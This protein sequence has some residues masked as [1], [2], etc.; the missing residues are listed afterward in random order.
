MDRLPSE[1]LQIIFEYSSDEDLINLPYSISCKGLTK[2]ELI[3]RFAIYRGVWIE[4]QSLKLLIRASNHPLIGHTIQ[5]LQFDLDRIPYICRCEFRD[6]HWSNCPGRSCQ[7]PARRGHQL[8]WHTAKDRRALCSPEAAYT[9]LGPPSHRRDERCTECVLLDRKWA[10]YRRDQRCTECVLLGRKWARYRSLY[11]SQCRLAEKEGDIDI[12]TLAFKVLAS[13]KAITIANE[14]KARKLL[15]DT[16]CEELDHNRTKDSGAHLMKVILKALARSGLKLQ[17]FRQ[18]VSTGPDGVELTDVSQ[19]LSRTVCQDIFCHL[20]VLKLR[21]IHYSAEE[22]SKYRQWR[23]LDEDVFGFY[24]RNYEHC[25]VGNLSLEPQNEE[26]NA[27]SESGC[28][29]LTLTRHGTTRALAV[30]LASCPSIEDLQLGIAGAWSD[31]APHIPLL[32][33]LGQNNQLASLRRLDLACCRMEEDQLSGALLRC[34][35]TLEMLSLYGIV[36]DSGTWTSLFE[37]LRGRFDR[38]TD[39]KCGCEVSF[40]GPCFVKSRTTE[41]LN[42]DVKLYYSHSIIWVGK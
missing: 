30:I 5:E 3:R 32:K 23:E 26:D 34:A 22:I 9:S 12:M 18:G 17:Q 28:S 6:R 15:G 29:D 39:F 2:G 13:L 31:A 4:E 8:A 35:P 1:L 37:D 24:S 7:R 14:H 33:M 40:L 19:V 11:Q 42:T 38:L 10:S 41:S 16:W 20:K 27:H 21:S 36:L 25:D